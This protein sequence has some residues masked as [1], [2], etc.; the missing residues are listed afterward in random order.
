M[1]IFHT[2]SCFGTTENGRSSQLCYETTSQGMILLVGDPER[3]GQTT[4]VWKAADDEKLVQ[5][6]IKEMDNK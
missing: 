3:S 5:H 1:P 2:M 4:G 6:V